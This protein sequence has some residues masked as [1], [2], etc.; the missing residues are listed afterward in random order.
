MVDKVWYIGIENY[1]VSLGVY[2]TLMEVKHELIKTE[3][4]VKKL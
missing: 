3:T 2:S 4:D 1:M